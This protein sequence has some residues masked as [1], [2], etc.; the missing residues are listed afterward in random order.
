MPAY[1]QGI[2]EKIGE[3]L[4]ELIKQKFSSTI[5][6]KTMRMKIL[7]FNEKIIKLFITTPLLPELLLDKYGNYVVQCAIA[8]AEEPERDIMLKV[9]F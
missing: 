8:V 4:V 7:N 1:K 5:I 6:E 2:M 3:N 9:P